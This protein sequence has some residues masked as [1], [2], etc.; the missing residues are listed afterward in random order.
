MFFS[1]I[2]ELLIFGIAPITFFS[3]P[4]HSIEEV[5]NMRLLRFHNCMFFELLILNHTIHKKI[6]LPDSFRDILP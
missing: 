3:Y 2:L 6:H 5:L 1:V 4:S